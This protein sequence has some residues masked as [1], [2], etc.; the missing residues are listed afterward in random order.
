MKLKKLQMPC[1]FEQNPCR[2]EDDIEVSKSEERRKK[3]N[4]KNNLNQWSYV[5]TEDLNTE[6]MLK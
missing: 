1:K 3:K 6:S 2:N 4:N 5:G